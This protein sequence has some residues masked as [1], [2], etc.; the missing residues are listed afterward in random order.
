MTIESS[1]KT[2]QAGDDQVPY[3]FEYDHGRMPFFM[4]IVWVGFIVLATVYIVN[5]LLTA[6]SIEVSG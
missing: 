3:D 6:L 4:K 5:H 1:E 2:D